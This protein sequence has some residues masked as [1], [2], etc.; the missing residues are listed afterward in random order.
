MHAAVKYNG[1]RRLISAAGMAVGR[2]EANCEAGR[3]AWRLEGNCVGSGS[4]VR[5][6]SLSRNA[7]ENRRFLKTPMSAAVLP[8]A[9]GHTARIAAEPLQGLTR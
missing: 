6:R 9:G 2:L 7:T 1:G 5:R 8:P 4:A 3:E